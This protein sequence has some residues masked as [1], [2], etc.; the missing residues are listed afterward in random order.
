MS[1]ARPPIR[2][3]FYYHYKHDPLQSVQN[4]AYEVLGIGRDTE[5]EANSVLYRPLYA[6]TYFNGT[7][8]SVRP[9]EMFTG[10]VEKDGV[11]VPRFSLITDKAVLDE[12]TKIRKEMYGN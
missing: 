2:G 5:T 6:S 9:Y 4:Y 12:L 7:D 10:T 3:G 1:A 8:A 11:Q